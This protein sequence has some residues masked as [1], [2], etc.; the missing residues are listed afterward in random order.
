LGVAENRCCK[1]AISTFDEFQLPCS[2]IEYGSDGIAV[3]G[4][5]WNGNRRR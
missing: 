3:P 4:V 2:E 1:H 5:A